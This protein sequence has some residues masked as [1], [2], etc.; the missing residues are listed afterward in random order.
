MVGTDHGNYIRCSTAALR[1]DDIYLCPVI[2]LSNCQF[3]G[4]LFF[5]KFSQV[6]S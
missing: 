6:L 5:L 4:R 1:D 3:E 2:R